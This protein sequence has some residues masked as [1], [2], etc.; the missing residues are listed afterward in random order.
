MRTTRRPSGTWSTT[1]SQFAA[2][3]QEPRRPVARRARELL[4]DA[5][6]RTDLAGHVDGAGPRDVL[7]VR[8]VLGRHLVDDAEREHGPGAG[9]ADV[10][11]ADRHVD[12]HVERRV[13]EDPDLRAAVGL[14][15]AVT[16]GMSTAWPC[17]RTVSVTVVPGLDVVEQP[18]EPLVVGH[19]GAVE[20]DDDVA[21][22]DLALRVGPLDGPGDDE[23]RGD[24]V[25]QLRER[26]DRGVLLRGDHLGG[27]RLVDLVL[28]PVRRV[29]QLDRLHDRPRREP[30]L[31][32]PDDARR[33]P[34]PARA[35]HGGQPQLAGRV[36][37]LGAGDLDER[38]AVVLAQHVAR[39][40]GAAHRVRHRAAPRGRPAAAR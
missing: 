25:A 31:Q 27:V 28:R 33:E 24:L 7:A 22:L 29:E 21:L 23:R 19:R 34:G 6:D 14:L 8:L 13:D 17:R 2:G 40:A 30:A 15:G 18:D 12:G 4:P 38:G 10:V 20:G 9:A 5:A 26:G 37:R 32:D 35:R 16:I 36:E 11:D 3:R 39:G 1:S